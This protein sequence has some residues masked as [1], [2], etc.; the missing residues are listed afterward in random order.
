MLDEKD[1]LVCVH[2]RNILRARGCYRYVKVPSS[3][4]KRGS[5]GTRKRIQT[6]WNLCYL[7]RE[8]QSLCALTLNLNVL[9][10]LTCVWA[11]IQTCR[12]TPQQKQFVLFLPNPSASA[13]ASS[14]ATPVCIRL[15]VLEPRR[16]LGFCRRPSPSSLPAGRHPP[17]PPAAVHPIH[18]PP[19]SLWPA[20]PHPRPTTLGRVDPTRQSL[21]TC[22]RSS[23]TSARRHPPPSAAIHLRPCLTTTAGRR[24]HQEHLKVCFFSILIKKID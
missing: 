3:P 10:T 9:R 19:S 22:C 4:Y 12:V 5:K 14:P 17:Y 18:R 15:V 13:P 11:V 21:P 24:I 16:R 8:S 23:S 6:F 7:Q 20:A 1:I 2:T